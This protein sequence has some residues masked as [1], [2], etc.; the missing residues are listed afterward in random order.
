MPLTMKDT[1]PE[2]GLCTTCSHY[3]YR[4]M[5]NGTQMKF[6]T[7]FDEQQPVRL[8]APITSCSQYN[9]ESMPY[10]FSQLAWTYDG[11]GFLKPGRYRPEPQKSLWRK[12]KGLFQ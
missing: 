8:P 9:A 2:N 12:L 7:V 6:C 3:A 5:S 4:A 1:K 11:E 10:L